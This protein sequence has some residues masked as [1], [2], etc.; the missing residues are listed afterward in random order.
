MRG[1][2]ITDNKGNKLGVFFT[3]DEYNK[4]IEELEELEDIRLYDKSKATKEPSYPIEEAFK[5]V[6]EERQKKG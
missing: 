4:I 3:I 6:E 1:Q 2:V 5:M